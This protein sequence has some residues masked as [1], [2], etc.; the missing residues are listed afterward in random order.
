M[1]CLTVSVSVNLWR[2]IREDALSRLDEAL[3]RT[4]VS[5]LAVH[6]GG[7]W[8]SAPAA[9][10]GTATGL[11]PTGWVGPSW[12]NEEVDSADCKPWPLVE[13]VH[14]VSAGVAAVAGGGHAP[15]LSHSGDSSGCDSDDHDRDG[16]HWQ[17]AAAAHTAL[18]NAL[19]SPQVIAA[20]RK[21][22]LLNLGVAHP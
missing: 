6:H 3:A 12:F 1:R 11:G 21:Q 16:Q 22:L 14:H 17:R 19:L 4:V 13:C 15:E 7:K 9:P 5:A 18:A 20:V 8:P 2:P 10:A